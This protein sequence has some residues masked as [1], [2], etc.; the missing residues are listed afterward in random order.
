MRRKSGLLLSVLAGAFG[1]I[2]LPTATAQADTTTSC[3][4]SRTRRRLRRRCTPW[5]PAP[6]SLA[7]Q[8]GKVWVG[9]TADS[10]PGTGAIGD[11]NLSAATPATAFE[12]ATAGPSGW[13]SAPGLAVDIHR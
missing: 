11:I 13:Y 7:V 5:P 4:S 6:Y 10:T 3:R 1:L 9:Y 2:V 8:S 12:P